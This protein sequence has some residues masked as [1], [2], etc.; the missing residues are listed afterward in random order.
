[1]IAAHAAVGLLENPTILQLV[2][3]LSG[4]A[5]GVLAAIAL[6]ALSR[7][8]SVPY[9]LV[10]MALVALASKAVVGLAS[11]GGYVD[12]TTHNLLEHGIDFVVATL[13]IA[14]IVEARHPEG[15]A[16]GKWWASRAE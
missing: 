13:L 4:I 10:A 16:I 7:R 12:G 9:L 1:M 14:A 3:I 8:R 5:S 15:C 11:I 2:V 6:I